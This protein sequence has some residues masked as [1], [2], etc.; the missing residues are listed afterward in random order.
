MNDQY[1]TV[2]K[3]LRSMY[4]K[5]R[6]EGDSGE[7]YAFARGAA[8][9][10]RLLNGLE[11]SHWLAEK[12][13]HDVTTCKIPFYTESISVKEECIGKVPHFLWENEDEPNQRWVGSSLRLK[14]KVYSRN[15]FRTIC[16]SDDTSDVIYGPASGWWDTCLTK[17][18]FDR[19][20]IQDD[21]PVY[22]DRYENGHYI[23]EEW[24]FV[25]SVWDRM[26]FCYFWATYS[27]RD[28]PHWPDR[29][30]NKLCVNED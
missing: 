3:T 28:A 29:L 6:C 18:A 5:Y 4:E 23:R 17:E 1:M 16:V 14:M 7:A 22:N 21:D 8:E 13:V 9:M 30:L 20:P 12:L 24:D 27:S 10:Y 19:N 26:T 11:E 15:K 2:V 25:Y